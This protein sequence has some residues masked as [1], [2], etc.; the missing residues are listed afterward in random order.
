MIDAAAPRLQESCLHSSMGH[1]PSVL[2]G[3]SG[4]M[5]VRLGRLGDPAA[6]CPQEKAGR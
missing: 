4:V 3:Q 1:A 2:P 6:G 5:G